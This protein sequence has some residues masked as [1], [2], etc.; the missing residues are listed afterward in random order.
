MASSFLT[1]NEWIT[2]KS[3][4]PQRQGAKRYNLRQF[5]EGVIYI[6]QEGCRWRSLPRKFGYWKSIYHRFIRWAKKGLWQE[7]F[8]RLKGAF[9][10]G[11]MA[12]IDATIVRVQQSACGA[13]GGQSEQKLGWSCGGLTT[14]IH[15]C[16]NEFGV[17]QNFILSDGREHEMRHVYRVLSTSIFGKSIVMADRGYDADPLRN[18][19]TEHGIL[20]NIPGR[21]NRVIPIIYDKTLYRSRNIVERYFCCLKRF[22]RLATRYEKLAVTFSALIYLGSSLSALRFRPS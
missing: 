15:A 9:P 17:L 8:Q 4:I 1:E 3:C 6:L 12:M 20:P 18:K 7:M 10:A 11:K 21:D 5:I 14:K 16:V 19:L 22:R 2:I 13:R